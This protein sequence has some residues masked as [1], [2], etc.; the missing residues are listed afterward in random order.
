MRLQ[1]A[2][3]INVPDADYFK[4]F[5]EKHHSGHKKCPSALAWSCNGN[6]LVTA[7]NNIKS[8]HFNEEYGLEKG[9][10]I[11]GH[12]SNIDWAEFGTSQLLGTLSR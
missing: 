10:E 4:N 1:N 5:K 9:G 6:L 12:D 7:E 11:R 3:G 2:E 8:W